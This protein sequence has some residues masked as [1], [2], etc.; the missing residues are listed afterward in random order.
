MTEHAGGHL[1]DDL[2]ML[3][4]ERRPLPHD[5]A[6]P[7]QLTAGL[8]SAAGQGG[9]VGLGGLDGLATAAPRPAPVAD[10]PAATTGWRRLLA[11]RAHR[12]G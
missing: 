5:A 4:I 7:R 1:R 2:A 11:G 3:L 8:D 6:V 9:G 12:A 10:G